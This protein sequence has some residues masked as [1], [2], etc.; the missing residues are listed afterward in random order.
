MVHAIFFAKAEK[1]HVNYLI[2]LVSQFDIMAGNPLGFR[3]L[4][5]F[6]QFVRTT[7]QRS[8]WKPKDLA[9]QKDLEC[10]SLFA[11]TSPKVV[12]RKATACSVST[13][14]AT[15]VIRPFLVKTGLV[16]RANSALLASGEGRNS[17]PHLW[18]VTMPF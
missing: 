3:F 4:M 6:H 14:T 13:A 7:E 12:P 1:C 2:E 10:P 16:A 11:S 8:V 9:Q 18:V 15:A 17:A 5:V